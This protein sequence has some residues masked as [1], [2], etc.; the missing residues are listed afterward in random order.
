MWLIATFA[1]VSLDE[2]LTAA[3]GRWPWGDAVAKPTNIQ[4]Q[5]DVVRAVKELAEQH[6]QEEADAEARLR[7]DR[8]SADTALAQARE[9][10]DNELRRAFEMLQEADRLALPRGGKNP[11]GDISPV[12]PP[13]LFDTDLQIGLR[14][15]TAQMEARLIRIRGSFGDGSSGNLITVGIIVGAIVA[16]G[17]ILAVPFGAGGGT[18]SLS[19]GWFGAM[20]SPLILAAL[21]AGARATVLRPYTPDDDYQFIRDSM[22]HIL[23]MHQVLVDEARNTYD[24]RLNERQERFDEARD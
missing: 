8:E 5:R 16:A 18:G 6:V 3:G 19:L 22:G 14:I 15:A 7:L 12:A 13:K 23:S 10:A 4:E 17:A 9:T 20:I 2:R 21:V 24:R 1:A 11:V